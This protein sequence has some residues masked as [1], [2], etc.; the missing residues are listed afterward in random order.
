MAISAIGCALLRLCLPA[1]KGVAWERPF[2]DRI[3][4]NGLNEPGQPAGCAWK[5]ERNYWHMPQSLCIFVVN[6]GV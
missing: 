3:P 1:V 6:S 2:N 4:K 5:P